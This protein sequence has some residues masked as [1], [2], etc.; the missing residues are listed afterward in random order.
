[1]FIKDRI[2]DYHMITNEPVKKAADI[3]IEDFVPTGT[4]KDYNFQSLV[5]N[6]SRWLVERF[7]VAF[8]SIN[9]SAFQPKDQLTLRLPV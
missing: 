8:K 6:Y 3:K 9:T 1:M 2:D 7:P 4:E 5:F